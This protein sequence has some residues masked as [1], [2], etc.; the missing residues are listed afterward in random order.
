MR[1]TRLFKT[2]RIREAFEAGKTR[3]FTG[4]PCRHGHIA[5]RMVS[6]S[7]CCECLRIRRPLYESAYNPSNAKLYNA[8]SPKRRW[9]Y[10]GKKRQERLE[11]IAGRPRPEH[12]EI[13]GSVAEIVFDHCHSSDQFRGWICAQCNRILGGVRDSPQLLRKLAAYLEAHGKA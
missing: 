7:N 1:E 3:Y 6:S 12:C 9:L 10:R 5:E 8:T 2:G 4:K 13:C 11:I